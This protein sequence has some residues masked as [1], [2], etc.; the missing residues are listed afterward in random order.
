MKKQNL[1][2]NK[3]KKPQK[4]KPKTTIFSKRKGPNNLKIV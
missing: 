3:S 4:T 2:P 1:S